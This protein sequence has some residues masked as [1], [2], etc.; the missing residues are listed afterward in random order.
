M[1]IFGG[2]LD[3]SVNVGMDTVMYNVLRIKNICICIKVL[4]LVF[5]H[6]KF[7]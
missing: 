7:F 4:V 2:N 5:V 1:N 6:T 3:L